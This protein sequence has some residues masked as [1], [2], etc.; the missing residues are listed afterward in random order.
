MLKNLKIVYAED[1]TLSRENLKELLEM[2]CDNVFVAQDGKE[3]WELYQKVTPDILIS[4]IEMPYLNGLQLSEKIREKDKKIQI[5]ITTAYTDTEYFLKA[6]ELNLVKY[7]V[8]PITYPDLN[9]SLVKAIKNI[10]S[11]EQ[12]F[13]KLFNNYSYD[14]SSRILKNEMKDIIHLTH[15]EMLLLELLL[16]N[17]NNVVTYEQIESV[18]W[19]Y[20][21]NVISSDALRSLV[22]D[23]RK[24]L[25]PQSIKN[26]AKIGYKIQL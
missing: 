10:T 1:E 7:L 25:P 14:I 16:K 12:P 5:I 8:K 22:R 21:C 20:S 3:A 17:I 11:L 6:I 4:D 19:D 23:I 13:Y 26:I 24:K 9:D 15:N 18:L 2:S